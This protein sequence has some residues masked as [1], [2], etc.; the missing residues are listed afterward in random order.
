MVYLKKEEIFFERDEKGELL[1]IETILE[2]IPDKPTIVAT[3]LT[4]GELSKIVAMSGTETDADTDIN[5]VISHCKNPAFTEVDRESLKSAGK[6]LL[7]N[8]IAIAIFSISTGI[9][10]SQLLEEGK[11][12]LAEKKLQNFQNQ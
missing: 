9:S 1:P 3:P 4:K 8:A 2:T 6:S 7:I 11:K 10:Q 12:S 5:V